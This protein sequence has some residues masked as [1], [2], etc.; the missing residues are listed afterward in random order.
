MAIGDKGVFANLQTVQKA[1]LSRLSFKPSYFPTRSVARA[2]P[3]AFDR[4][5]MV[6]GLE[7]MVVVEVVMDRGRKARASTTRPRPQPRRLDDA[8]SLLLHS[9]FRSNLLATL[10]D[11]IQWTAISSGSR[12]KRGSRTRR[13]DRSGDSGS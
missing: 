5:V 1:S 2:I 4:F 9:L 8:L 13:H 10:S 7:M 6:I 12:K 3:R 11:L